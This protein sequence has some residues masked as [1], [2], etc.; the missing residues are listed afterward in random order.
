MGDQHGSDETERGEEV[1]GHRHGFL[2]ITREE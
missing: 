2:E 1:Q